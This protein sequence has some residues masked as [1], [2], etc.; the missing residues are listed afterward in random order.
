M[1]DKLIQVELY[2]FKVTINWDLVE[3]FPAFLQL[4]DTPQS[5]VWHAEGNAWI[6]TCEVVYWA[7]YYAGT[8]GLNIPE[9]KILVLA[10]LF[11]DIG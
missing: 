7:N 9:T 10:A 4:K 1:I 2:P 8:L 6:H 5:P 11:H 3:S